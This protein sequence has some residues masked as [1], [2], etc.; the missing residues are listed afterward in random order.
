MKS[1]NSVSTGMAGDVSPAAPITVELPLSVDA[2]P[3]LE[4]AS[5]SRKK[6]LFRR[7]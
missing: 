2:E 3:E 4:L 7:V 6:G 5:A 1:Q